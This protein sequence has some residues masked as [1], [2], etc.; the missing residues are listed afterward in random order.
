M[1]LD[2]V[3]ANVELLAVLW[4]WVGWMGKGPSVVSEDVSVWAGEAVSELFLFAVLLFASL[5]LSILW[6]GAGS[7]VV[8]VDEPTGACHHICDSINTVVE[9]VTN[10]WVFMGEVAVLSW[11]LNRGHSR[12]EL[13]TFSTVDGEGK[14]TAFMVGALD[15]EEE[16]IRTELLFWLGIHTLIVLVALLRVCEETVWLW[17]FECGGEPKQGEED[18][19]SF[20]HF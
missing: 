2:S 16:T 4:M 11:A 17:T 7:L 20:N 9:F 19:R 5:A 1:G 10:L 8:I 12:L 15:F 3:S 13:G 18:Y 14:I 6:P